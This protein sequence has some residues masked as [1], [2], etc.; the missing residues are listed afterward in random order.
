[1][2]C[3]VAICYKIWKFFLGPLNYLNAKIINFCDFQP[4]ILFGK[5]NWNLKILIDSGSRCATYQNFTKFGLKMAEGT[6]FI[7]ESTMKAYP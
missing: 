2:N 7:R 3:I 6:F 1:M 4:L 5:T